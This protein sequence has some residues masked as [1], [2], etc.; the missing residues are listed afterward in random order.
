MTTCESTDQVLN[1]IDKEV[2]RAVGLHGDYHSP[3]QAYGV[4][5]EEVKEFFDEVCKKKFDKEAARKELTQ[6]AAV[7]VRAI[8]DL[9]Q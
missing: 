7:C 4:L 6:I 9:C 2:L 1:D 3:H 8:L 5:C